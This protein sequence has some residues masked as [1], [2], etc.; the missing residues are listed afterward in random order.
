[1]GIRGP[2]AFFRRHCIRAGYGKYGQQR[3][4]DQHGFYV[5]VLSLINMDI[6]PETAIIYLFYFRVL[7]HIIHA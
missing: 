6:I 5:H 3:T 4:A 1:M 7:S 2:A